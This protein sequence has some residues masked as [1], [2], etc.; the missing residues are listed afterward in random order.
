MADKTIND[1]T[2]IAAAPAGASFVP[3][4]ESGATKKVSVT[5]LL[6]NAGGGIEF[7][8]AISGIGSETGQVADADTLL[9]ALAKINDRLPLSAGS[10][11]PVAGDLYLTAEMMIGGLT[12]PDTFLHIRGNPVTNYGHATFEGITGDDCYISFQDSA[13]GLTSHVG[14]D[15]NADSSGAHDTVLANLDGGS[16]KFRTGSDNT[17][18]G[19]TT[20][21]VVQND[22][23]ATII[24]PGNND[25]FLTHD[26]GYGN[27]TFSEAAGSMKIK[28]TASAG[29]GVQIHW[30]GGFGV[31]DGGFYGF[32][33]GSDYSTQPDTRLYRDAESVI[34][35]RNGTNAQTFR[36]Y[37]TYTDASNFERLSLSADGAGT[38]TIAAE[39]LGTG[40]DNIDI[41]ITPAGTGNLKFGTHAAIGSETVT[42]YIEI[43]DSSGTTRKV[44]IVS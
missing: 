14:T 36:L 7:S 37:G 1:L 2:D 44:A 19:L 10:S 20:R 35:Q 32:L 39:T 28:A 4:W 31:P 22:G 21:F 17:L 40:T 24:T 16:I 42:G 13:A 23:N 27:A 9:A 26:G 34:A 18:A 3:V 41:A 5:N 8:T 33:A 38:C 11:Y 6:T 43:K 12:A 30:L 29:I 15:Y 25:V